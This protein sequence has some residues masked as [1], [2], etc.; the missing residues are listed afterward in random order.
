MGGDVSLQS[1]ANPI[2][3]TTLQPG[4]QSVVEKPARQ[5]G[6]G[7]KVQVQNDV[8]LGERY[9]TIVN[10]DSATD[11][12][13][14]DSHIEKASSASDSMDKFKR[15]FPDLDGLLPPGMKLGLMLEKEP[16]G[17]VWTEC[18]DQILS[19]LEENK[20]GFR[21]D[22]LS[23]LKMYMS[24]NSQ[25]FYQN[26]I[27]RN[28][29]GATLDELRQNA[30]L[31]KDADRITP[32]VRDVFEDVVEA[33]RSFINDGWN[34]PS[35]NQ[36]LP[37]YDCGPQSSGDVKR[38]CI[39]RQSA[40]TCYMMSV[41]NGLARTEAGVSHLKNLFDDDKGVF[42]AFVG[43]EEKNFKFGG[44]TTFEKMLHKAY[45]EQLR[46]DKVRK[47]EKFGDFGNVNDLAKVLGLDV[48]KAITIGRFGPE[49]K[50]QEFSIAMEVSKA[51]SEGKVCTLLKGKGPHYRAI[52]GVYLDQN[53][54]AIF[55]LLDSAGNPPK[56]VCEPVS[57][58]MQSATDEQ[59]SDPSVAVPTV[60]F[61][62]LPSKGSKLQPAPQLAPKGE[63]PQP[64]PEFKISKSAPEVDIPQSVA[65]ENKLAED[66]VDH[67][68]DD[69]VREIPSE[70]FKNAYKILAKLSKVSGVKSKNVVKALRNAEAQK[71]LLGQKIGL[72]LAASWFRTMN[73][74]GD[75]NDRFVETA[76]DANAD[77][78]SEIT[79]FVNSV[80]EKSD[81]SDDVIKQLDWL[82]DELAT[83]LT[84]YSRDVIR[85]AEDMYELARQELASNAKSPESGGQTLVADNSMLNRTLAQLA[86]SDAASAL[87]S[88]RNRLDTVSRSLDMLGGPSFDAEDVS[89]VL[90]REVEALQREL[91]SLR[92]GNFVIK[93]DLVK[94][95]SDTHAAL[96][97]YRRGLTDKPT[98]EV[99]ESLRQESVLQSVFH[100]RF[101]TDFYLYCRSENIPAE[102]IDSTFAPSRLHKMRVLDCGSN[103]VAYATE[104]T[105]LGAYDA[106]Q[107]GVFESNESY[108]KIDNKLFGYDSPDNPVVDEEKKE[109]F[110]SS[111]LS[112]ATQKAAGLFFGAG[113]RFVGVSSSFRVKSDGEKEFGFVMDRAP[114]RTVRVKVS[115]PQRD[116]GQTESDCDLLAAEFKKM[117]SER[118][119]SVATQILLQ[120]NDID[121]CDYLTGQV[122]RNFGNVMLDLDSQSEDPHAR[123]T[124]I[125]NDFSF[126]PRRIGLTRFQFPATELKEIIDWSNEHRPAKDGC[127]E[128]SQGK[129]EEAEALTK[130]GD[131]YILDV[132]KMPMDC[133]WIIAKMGIASLRRPSFITSETLAQIEKMHKRVE[134]HMKDKNAEDPFKAFSDLVPESGIKAMRLRFEELYNHAK[135]LEKAE[136]VFSREKLLSADPAT[137][138]KNIRALL[139][140]AETY[141][142]QIDKTIS[143]EIDRK[144]VYDIGY[145]VLSRIGFARNGH[146]V[147]EPLTSPKYIKEFGKFVEIYRAGPKTESHGVVTTTHSDINCRRMLH[148]SVRSLFADNLPKSVKAAL[149]AVEIS[150][151]PLTF[152]ELEKVMLAV[153]N[154]NFNH[155][156]ERIADRIIDRISWFQTNEYENDEQLVDERNELLD[157]WKVDSEDPKVIKASIREKVRNTLLL[158]HNRF[159][160]YSLLPESLDFEK[161]KT[162]FRSHIAKT[163]EDPAHK[164]VQGFYHDFFN[165]LR[166][167]TGADRIA[168]NGQPIK[169]DEK[170]DWKAAHEQHKVPDYEECNGGSVHGR[171]IVLSGNIKQKINDFEYGYGPLIEQLQTLIPNKMARE[172]VTFMSSV[173]SPAFN[174]VMSVDKIGDTFTAYESAKMVAEKTAR[175]MATEAVKGKE[176]ED[177]EAKKKEINRLMRKS[178]YYAPTVC[179][180]VD[181]ESYKVSIRTDEKGKVGVSVRFYQ[182]HILNSGVGFMVMQPKT[183]GGLRLMD[184]AYEITIKC[185]ANPTIDKDGVPEYELDVKYLGMVDKL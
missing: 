77:A 23:Y 84:L 72:E 47:I 169:F 124:G 151:L 56:V 178:G 67:L 159:L 83:G 164:S 71:N 29:T 46:N 74:T 142:T 100:G 53:G 138:E 81:L 45:T 4:V 82:D 108:L 127:A 184:N 31:S 121:W 5:T 123:L 44:Q 96:V 76:A 173:E 176:F 85:L 59:V 87:D 137:A 172:F 122:D 148:N 55:Q 36:Y 63:V 75:A 3:N 78:A 112:Y 125:D 104:H 62:E 156:V 155:L 146:S 9:Q 145:T 70:R 95:L 180:L 110:K 98:G 140:H 52:S 160:R 38:N 136:R 130:S 134:A 118:K 73:G 161:L 149:D 7:N 168:V 15:V 147:V 163:F 141:Q 34:A 115:K 51:L 144:N 28:K 32:L 133:Q 48:G 89:G 20:F 119:V 22:E 111:K 14:V 66:V 153:R 50:Y 152:K 6:V 43:G 33:Y 93:R 158:P 13:L 27:G 162:D 2:P 129:L 54:K 11:R 97:G 17:Q 179:A 40:N 166:S 60:N 116:K 154:Y 90:L 128:L 165:F 49:D 126:S 8:K 1:G 131:T 143:P 10:D 113:E 185:D 135:S 68:R 16:D 117:S 39:W 18:K 139:K 91:S 26:V 21:E 79:D 58:S 114:G 69:V 101:D 107:S 102:M 120:G 183:A 12:P 171:R 174:S 41:L 61:F 105:K 30:D 109:K 177:D 94:A 19:L 80:R 170:Y 25:E 37:T 42:K 24:R 167:K 132:E 64:A 182:T 150:D 57:N 157:T 99:G 103:N 92:G 106:T 88:I 86:K 175:D 181:Q 35:A 65:R